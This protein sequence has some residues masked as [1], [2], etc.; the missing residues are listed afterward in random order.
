MT[1][2][3]RFAADTI[4]L[5]PPST[6]SDTTQQQQL[7]LIEIAKDISTNA[8][9][10]AELMYVKFTGTVAAGDF[11][12][13]DLYNKTCIA[14]PTS[15]ASALGFGVGISLAAQ[16]SGKY[17]WILISG[18]HDAANIADA[19]TAGQLL[20][21]SGTA[22][23]AGTATANYAFDIA[24]AKTDASAGNVGACILQRPFCNGR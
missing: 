21:G 15:A 19:V 12:I 23:R 3:Y 11:V 16:S 7:G 14:S 18:V 17:G 4:G 24:T 13:F 6:V 10:I 1:V 8:Y 22:G 5:P 9:G 20:S 2:D